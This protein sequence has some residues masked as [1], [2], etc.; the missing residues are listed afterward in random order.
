MVGTSDVLFG[1]NSRTEKDQIEDFIDSKYI[2][3][4]GIVKT[5]NSDGT[6][7]VE[8][9]CKI[10]LANG[11][12]VE[13]YTLTPNVEVLWPSSAE[14]SVKFKLTAGDRVLLLGT[15]Y[16]V[17]TVNITEPTEPVALYHYSQETLKAIPVCLHKTNAKMVIEI[18]NG[19]LM[20]KN[21]TLSYS[22][23][24]IIDEMFNALTTGWQ[25]I[26]CVPGS[27]VTPLATT[28]TAL[29]TAKA[30]FDS[31]FKD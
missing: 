29:N 30:K 4:Y 12:T 17:P 11:Q 10:V 2:V 25:S 16:H 13:P 5:V 3:D 19:A 8:H 9:A 24:A 6:V 21:T 31:I 20:L 22:L 18:E 1:F 14:F 27:P 7:D 23:K 26:P 28:I 15:K